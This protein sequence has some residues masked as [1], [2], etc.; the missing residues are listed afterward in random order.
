MTSSQP[1]ASRSLAEWDAE[2]QLQLTTLEGW[3]DFVTDTLTPPRLLTD[4]EHQALSET[5]QLLDDEDRIDYHARTLV[6]ATPAIRHIVT[7]GRR[8]VLMNR[9]ERGA[10]RGL[11]VSGPASTGKS[12]AITQLGLSHELADRAR[13]P[14][15]TDRIPVIYVTVPPAATARMIAAEF[16]RFLGLPVR[17]RLNMTDIIEAVVGVLIDARCS[18]V[19][20]DEVHNISLTT[21]NGAEVSDTLK[22]FSERIPATFVYAGLDLDSKG[23][24][25]GTRGAQIAGRFTLIRTAPFALG[26]EWS[27][28]VATLEDTL[29]LRRHRPNTLRKLDGWLHTHTGGMIGALSHAVRGAAIDAILTST[30]K[31]TRAGIEAIPLDYA[32]ES[33]RHAKTARAARV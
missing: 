12:I 5:E 30:E 28:L 33:D 4:Q 23:L 15:V 25:E 24:L 16:A 13:H 27:R 32:A 18:L 20:V 1:P 3:R 7:C 2:T 14:G 22:Y 31:I 9:H 11:L 29:R 19:L 8:Q 21:R 10:R 6:V 17:T 26:A